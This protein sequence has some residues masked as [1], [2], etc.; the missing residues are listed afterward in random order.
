MYRL[1][2]NDRRQIV[3]Q[4][5]RFAA[6]PDTAYDGSKIGH[7]IRN[8]KT[9]ERFELLIEPLPV[10]DSPVRR[11]VG[12]EEITVGAVAHHARSHVRLNGQHYGVGC[13]VENRS[14]E[15]AFRWISP[16][17]EVALS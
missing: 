10:F 9:G 15:L 17:R 14:R 13:R 5:R 8:R 3:N 2:G 12:I 11:F 1:S 16:K 4:N 7:R 6:F